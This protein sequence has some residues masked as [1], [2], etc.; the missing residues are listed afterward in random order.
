MRRILVAILLFSGISFPQQKS[1]SLSQLA[2]EFWKWRAI[3][4]PFTFDDV[5]RLEHAGGIRDW[6]EAAIAKQRADLSGFERHWEAM[7]P[8]GWPMAQRIDYRLIGSALAR[9]R[10]ELDINPRWQR[11]PTFYVEQTVGALEEAVLPPPPFSEDRSGEIMARAENIPSILEQAKVNLK[12]VTPF[13]QL[14]IDSLADIDARF[15][16][17]EAGLSPLLAGDQR[18]RF[19]AAITKASTALV[20]YRE[21]LKLNLSRMKPDFALGE[22]AYGFF[23]HRVA[24]LPYTPE[25]LLTMARQDFDRVLAMESY[26]HQRDLNAPALKMAATAQ[27]EVARMEHDDASIRRYL[28]EHQILTVSPDLPHW[29]LRLAPNYIAAF[30][31]FGELDDFTGP[32]RLNQD[33]TRWIQ[34]PSAELPYFHKAY[35]N[36]TRTTGVHEGVPGHFFQLSLA[37]RN[38]DPIRRQYYDSGV[39]EGIG[40][41][42]EEMMLQ[43][44]LYDDNPRTREIIY[45]FARLRALRVEADVEL[46]LGEFSIDQAADYL[47]RTVPMDRKTA[48]SEAADFSTAPGLAIAYEIGKLQIEGMLAKRRLQQGDKFNLRE[49]HDYVWSNGNVPLSLQRW[50]LLGLDDELKRADALPK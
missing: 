40:F 3:Y 14:A 21:W 12:A 20:D 13:A 15:T 32:S 2:S 22:K 1:D 47:A 17:V 49:F 33:G 16:R 43:A 50:E 6:S 38:P 29:T 46:A 5:P 25:Q 44:G 23:L 10:W 31:G 30:D 9:V 45:N 34:P 26:E 28:V 18:A 7:R 37:W 36:D 48:E 39:N 19:H 8:E 41:Y 4:R 35:A 42:A 11:D 24:L 27:E